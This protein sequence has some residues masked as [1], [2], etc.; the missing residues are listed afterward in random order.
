MNKLFRNILLIALLFITTFNSVA[1]DRKAMFF[2]KNSSYDYGS[3]LGAFSLRKFNAWTNAVVKIRRSSDN[4]TAYV[5][6]NGALPYQTITTSSYISTSS[7]TTPSATTL[8]TWIG[9]DNGFVET[10]YLQEPSNSIVTGRAVSQTTTSLQPQIISSGSIL[11]KNGL[12]AVYF[13]GSGWFLNSLT[14]F[15]ELDS[16][17]D[18]TLLTVA[19]NEASTYLGCVFNSTNNLSEGFGIFMDTRTNKIFGFILSTTNAEVNYISQQSAGSQLLQSCILDSSRNITGYLNG[20]SQA[21]AS[22]TGNFT[23]ELFMVGKRYS[24]SQYFNGYIQEI[25]MFG[26]DKTAELA[27][28][29]A[30]INAYYSIF[31]LWFGFVI[32]F[33]NKKE[34][35]KNAS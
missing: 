15:S 19:S 12:P 3:I 18:M 20:T 4:A 33:K 34:Q 35:Y 17:N 14:T 31:F 29:Q 5:F 24:T 26:S 2:N 6:F 32:I 21:T 16:G 25:Q 1:Q 13:N 9:S 23:N 27:D 22:W 30:D 10:W 11:T 8:A 28:L 7:P